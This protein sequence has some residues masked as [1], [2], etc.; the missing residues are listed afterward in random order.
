MK[1]QK[2]LYILLGLLSSVIGYSQVRLAVE[3]DSRGVSENGT[4]KLTVVLEISGADMFQETPLR[5]PDL[6]KFNIIGDASEQN[7]YVD[8]QKNL[9]VNQQIYQY[10]LE[11]KQEGNIKMGS[12]LVTVN[13]KMYKSEPFDLYIDERVSRNSIPE[14]KRDENVY[15]DLEIEDKEIYENQPTIAVL[16]AYSKDLNNFRR[17]HNIQLPKQENIKVKPISYRKSEIE[18]NY[19]KGMAS[20]VLGVFMIFPKKSGKVE[21]D[22][23]SAIVKTSE[24]NTKI[25]SNKV[26]L[27]VKNLPES[28]PNNF[29]DAVGTFNID[30]ISET[31]L[32][33]TELEVGKPI[34]VLMKISG[35]GNLDEI[36]L[37]KLKP[38]SQ[39]S[40]YKPKI[41]SKTQATKKGE[42]GEVLVKYVVI[43]KTAGSVQVFTEPF[44]YFNPADGRYVNLV[45]KSLKFNVLSHEDILASKTTLEKVNEYSNDV[46]ET[47][48]TPIVETDSFK[49]KKSNYFSWKTV[50]IN[51]G[52]IVGAI[53]L[54][55]AFLGLRNHRKH[56]KET[57][58]NAPIS[59]VS[60]TEKAL[61]EQEK[62]DVSTYLAYMERLLDDHNFNEFFTT[63]DELCL[64]VEQEI[65]KENPDV[66]LKSFMEQ[67]KGDANAEKYRNLLQQIQMEK[68]APEPSLE[69]MEAIFL[70]IKGLFKD[71]IK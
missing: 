7:T 53:L 22:P 64:D 25:I 60:E 51:Y 33:N 6:S 65:Q 59:T 50:V 49:V 70:S 1:F 8:T 26:K 56:A 20:Q 66:S 11:P 29:K 54:L 67:Q 24:K 45:E 42:Q 18:Q 61:K 55:I 15:L 40:F 19:K 39:Y 41:V 14:K 2:L 5:S 4:V 3:A 27:N 16:R 47:V 30:L 44:T 10:L 69:H 68:Y 46:L 43:P 32:T 52:I 21:V 17:V 34:N 63:F 58:V 37:P 28:S 23:A 31:P 62:L 35:V 36:E 57:M 48:N 12:F 9:I 38:S 71:I 13:G